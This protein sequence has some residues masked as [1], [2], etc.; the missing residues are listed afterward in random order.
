MSY[1]NAKSLAD[2]FGG[3]LVQNIQNFAF[4]SWTKNAFIFSI[5]REIKLPGINSQRLL[6]A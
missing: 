6:A 5:R 1:Q 2:T 4:P 3:A